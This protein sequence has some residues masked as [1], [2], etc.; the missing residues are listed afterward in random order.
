M[1]D[2]A[3]KRT[4]ADATQLYTN[5]AGI[6]GQHRPEYNPEAISTFQAAVG[7]PRCT[8]VLDTGSGTGLLT[9]HLL[10]HYETVYALEPSANMQAVAAAKLGEHPG[11]KPLTAPAERIPLSNQSVDLIAAGQAIHWFQPEAA[12]VEFQ[13]IAKPGA[14][15]LL[16]YIKSR[17]EALNQALGT[18]FTEENGLMP[19]SEQPPSDLVPKS[20]YFAG[21]EFETQQFP[22]NHP[23]TWECFL[24]GMAT[25]AFA[26]NLDHPLYGNFIQ[27]ARKVFE[28][29]SKDGILDWKIATEISYGCLE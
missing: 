4:P 15:L 17:D 29:F 22:H 28:Q 5:K 6:Y 3:E 11:F 21:G 20:F 24:G 26:P 1:I 14:W 27:A 18:I 7:L 25:A 8:I 10:K 23:E 12:L 19:L 13:R 2:R 9:R 16:A